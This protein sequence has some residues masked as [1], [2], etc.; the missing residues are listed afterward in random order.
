MSQLFSYCTV[1]L[2]MKKFAVFWIFLNQW[3]MNHLFLWY[4]CNF[5]MKSESNLIKS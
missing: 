3:F 5:N 2:I 4:R 1:L